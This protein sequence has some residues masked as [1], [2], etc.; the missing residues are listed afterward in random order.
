MHTW[1][2]DPSSFPL[3][4]KEVLWCL[5]PHS[6]TWIQSHH[7]QSLSTS[8]VYIWS[9]DSFSEFL[10]PI[11]LLPASTW[12]SNRGKSPSVPPNNC[13]TSVFPSTK[14]SALLHIPQWKMLGNLLEPL[15]PHSHA[16]CQQEPASFQTMKVSH[17]LLVPS[18]HPNPIILFGQTAANGSSQGSIQPL[19]N[20][21]WP[22]GVFEK[23]CCM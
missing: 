11:C 19:C 14:G 22:E 17:H 16:V 1:T 10:L 8:H 5:Y 15:P 2:T 3:P 6:L 23:S 13:F 9:Q 18:L 20:R 7:L 21:E 4:H 12:S